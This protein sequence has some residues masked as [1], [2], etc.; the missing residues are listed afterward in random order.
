MTQLFHFWEYIRRTQNINS[1]EYMHPY[2]H[3]SAIYNS[4]DLEAAQV[5]I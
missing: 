3:C 1:K 5:P 2:G 4:Q